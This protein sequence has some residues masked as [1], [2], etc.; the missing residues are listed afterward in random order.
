MNQPCPFCG[1]DVDDSSEEIRPGIRQCPT[2]GQKVDMNAQP[3]P[4]QEPQPEQP[5][6]QEAQQD[7]SGEEQTGQAPPPPP[8]P[9]AGAQAEAQAQA[10]PT[11]HTPAWELDGGV[12]LEKMWKTIWQVALHPMLTFWAP[13]R[14]KQQYPLGFGLILGTFGSVLSVFWDSIFQLG[15]ANPLSPILM[16]FLAP[17]GVLIGLYVGTAIIHLFLIIVRGATGGFTATFRV[18][19]YSYATYIF[20]AIP[21]LG[22]YVAVVWMLVVQIAGLAA[23]HG[24]TRWRVASALLL[25]FGVVLLLA[26][27]GAMLIGFGAALTEM[28]LQISS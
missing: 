7:W 22:S 20:M 23:T 15:G 5:A 1:T 19:G 18:S 25:F 16:I 21:V 4:P 27:L 28:D 17:F 10:G 26:F 14:M 3:A 2:C 24:V 9:G 6:H 12:W 13:G 8:P 11:E